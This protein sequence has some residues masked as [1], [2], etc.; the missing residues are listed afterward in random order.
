MVRESY[1]IFGIIYCSN[2][3]YDLHT[4]I[5]T[6]NLTMVVIWQHTY[7]HIMIATH[8]LPILPIGAGGLEM[9]GCA[10]GGPPAGEG[11]GT[12]GAFT[13]NPLRKW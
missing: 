4:Y 11:L 6:N 12:E 1:Q 5:H 10:G 7:T 8:N 2:R 13:R 9:T 3:L